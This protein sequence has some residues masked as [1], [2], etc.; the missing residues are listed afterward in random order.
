MYF[1]DVLNDRVQ[2]TICPRNCILQEGQEGFC[3][4]RKNINGQIVLTSYGYNTGLAI[5]PIE[6][7]P[8]FHFYPNSTVLSFGTL[9]CI[10]GCRFC[11]NWHIS[12]GKADARMLNPTSPADIVAIAKAHNC[13]SVAFTYNDPVAFF[14]YAIGTAKLCRENGIKTVAVTSGYINQEPAKEF[15]KY[16]DAANID[17]KAFSEKFYRKNCLAHLQP[18]LDTIKYVKNHTDCWLELTTL[19][20]EGEN[21]SDEEIQSECRWILD[22]LGEDVPLHFSAFFPNYKFTDRKATDYKTLLNAYNI[23]KAA[24]LNY[25]YIGNSSV[26]ETAATYCKNCGKPVIKRVGYGLGEYNL[27]NDRC[28]FCGEKCAGMF[29]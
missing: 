19:L 23:A 29:E 25:V 5:D 3:H 8:L 28:M 21:T 24:G 22:N 7:K 15:F 2:C 26:A 10:M 20:I 12:R 9:G 1:Q 17:L 18:V 4:I 27:D 16:M 6:K 14:E 11:Q 13:K